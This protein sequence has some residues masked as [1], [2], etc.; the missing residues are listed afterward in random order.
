[1]IILGLIFY[2]KARTFL[3]VVILLQ[4]LVIVVHLQALK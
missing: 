4:L 2:I 3:V 1:M